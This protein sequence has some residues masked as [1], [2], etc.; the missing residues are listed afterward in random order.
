[1]SGLIH[2]DAADMRFINRMNQRCASRIGRVHP[3]LVAAADYEE[4]PRLCIEGLAVV[5][6]E[7]IGT[8]TGEILV[9]ENGAFDAHF[10][11]NS[12]TEVWLAHDPTEI[13]CS[14][15][16]GLEFVETDDGLAFRF[17]LDN[18]RYAASIERMVTSGKQACISV[19]ITR[20]KERKKT[21]GRHS[22]TFIESAELRECSLVAAGACDQ[23][24]A[25]LIDA[26]HSPS[27]RDSVN[28]IPFQI[29][30]GMHNIK[31][32]R[33]KLAARIQALQDRTAALERR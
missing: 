26:N 29:E 11:N 6:D 4:E 23:A 8:K 25:R 18:K 28:S 22:V 30:S 15:S 1:M 12:R 3:T 33:E 10:S 20:T 19:G 13:I 7:P 31:T 14:T 2:I 16:S 21:V 5:F 9:I 24:F 17:P 27:L 32:Q